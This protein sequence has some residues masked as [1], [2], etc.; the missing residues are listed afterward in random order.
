VSEAGWERRGPR[1][2]PW[3][4]R[5]AKQ[6]RKATPVSKARQGRPV[7]PVLLFGVAPVC[8]ALRVTP[9]RKAQEAKRASE[10]IARLVKPAQRVLK[11]PPAPQA[12]R[13]PLAF[14]VP[15]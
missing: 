4:V 2:T 6:A 12:Q 7:D 11:V 5:A 14:V 13:D 3:R 8:K 15:P 1:A 10:V 9:V